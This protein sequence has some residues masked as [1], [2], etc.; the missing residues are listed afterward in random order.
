AHTPGATVSHRL[1]EREIEIAK[2]SG[3]NG[4]LRHWVL[5]YVVNTLFRIHC[6]QKSTILADADVCARALIVRPDNISRTVEFEIVAAYVDCVSDIHAHVLLTLVLSDQRHTQDKHSHADVRHLHSIIA[7][8]LAAELLQDADL[9]SS[10]S[11]SL[12]DIQRRRRDDPERQQKSQTGQRFPSANDER[13]DECRHSARE[14]GPAQTHSQ[15][16]QTCFLPTGDWSHT[17]QK[18]S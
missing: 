8:C 2:Q 1:A 17:H 18:H 13:E 12:P 4:G 3:I 9:S 16:G 14:K 5:S 11:D 10:D 6:A 15:I 7:A